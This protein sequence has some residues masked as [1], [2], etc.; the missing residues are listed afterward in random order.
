V[1][2][3]PSVRL[4]AAAGAASEVV[5]ALGRRLQVRRLTALDRLRVF[6]AAGPA[7]SGNA[8][9]MGMATLAFSI[10]AIDDV[11]VPQPA[12][13]AQVEALVARLGDAGLAAASVQLTNAAA[14]Q[15]RVDAKN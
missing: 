11:P 13:E 15:P 7:L 12:S 9:W 3:T 4:V 5:D 6:K 10:A 8:G 14:G 2:E 1:S